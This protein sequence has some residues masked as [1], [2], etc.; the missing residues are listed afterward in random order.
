[1]M[2]TRTP[3]EFRDGERAPVGTSHYQASYILTFHPQRPHTQANK[4]A[5]SHTDQLLSGPVPRSKPS[6]FIRARRDQ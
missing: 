5:N 3:L 1:M 6:E 4:R 2:R